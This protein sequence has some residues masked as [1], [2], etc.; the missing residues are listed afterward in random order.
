MAE[1]SLKYRTERW[2]RYYAEK[3]RIMDLATPNS[4]SEEAEDHL[5]LLY[6][7]L[8]HPEP[9]KKHPMVVEAKKILRLR[10]R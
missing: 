5:R 2:E 4:V 1:A 8:P 7:D 10:G 6:A 9:L 3:K